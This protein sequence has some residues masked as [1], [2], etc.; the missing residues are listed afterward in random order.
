MAL[1]TL[2]KKADAAGPGDPGAVVLEVRGEETL[3]T[4]ILILQELKG[5]RAQLNDMTSLEE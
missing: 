3:Q 1:R 4:L 5:I 2:Q